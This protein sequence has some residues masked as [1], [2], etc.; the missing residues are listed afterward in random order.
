M[1]KS[2]SSLRDRRGVACTA[3]VLAALLL[4]I[5]GCDLA[6]SDGPT[7]AGD[8]VPEAAR[9]AKAPPEPPPLRSLQVY[10]DG[11]QSMA[12]YVRPGLGIA[13]PMADLLRLLS[14]YGD[15][16]SVPATFAAFGREIVEIDP[17][18][19][20]DR[21]S[22]EATY[23]CAG[24]DKNE[25][26]IDNVLE[27]SARAHGD[28]LTLIVTDLWLDNQ[29]FAGSPE[30]AL[31]GP[32][33]DTLRQGRAIGVIGLS[34]PFNGAV[35]GVPGVGTHKLAGERPLFLIA[36]GN[37]S[38]VLRLKEA[39][40]TSQSPIF[41]KERSH[42]TL[43]TTQWNV[44]VVGHRSVS[45]QG[46][47]VQRDNVLGPDALPRVPQF[48]IEGS[49]AAGQQG[50]VAVA[51]NQDAAFPEGLVWKGPVR[52]T[53]RVWQLSSDAELEICAA[54]TWREMGGLPSTWQKPLKPTEP[55]RFLLGAEAAGTLPPGNAYYILGEVGTSSLSVPN[56]D[57]AW[58][59]EWSLAADDAAT[60][61]AGAPT[62][63]KA[64][65]LASLAALMDQ[66]VA[67][68]TPKGVL[69]NRFGFVARIE[70]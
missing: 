65:N 55:P 44:P 64:L 42:F 51:V 59:R 68:Q 24:C 61:T 69:T 63:F 54:G 15:G 9:P 60:F 12:G 45:A 32:L 35:Y 43:Y 7:A 38:D 23:T 66:E 3:T 39:L 6:G 2:C 33:Q 18:A 49:V 62:N 16:Q 57:S 27:A 56:P 28:S 67:R 47:G 25:S 1:E 46:G 70:R 22:R 14:R 52:A 26:R 29:S 8:C 10:I 41:A 48:K 40:F 19:A 50:R 34:A 58:L 17:A 11:S 21:Y 5:S 20:V 31:G 53:T 36:L 4:A 30:V 37:P 13:N